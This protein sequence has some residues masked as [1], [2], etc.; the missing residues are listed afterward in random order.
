MVIVKKWRAHGTHIVESAVESVAVGVGGVV[1][2]S[3]CHGCDE[4]HWAFVG[5]ADAGSATTDNPA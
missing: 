1:V 2:D 5:A 4:W 3:A